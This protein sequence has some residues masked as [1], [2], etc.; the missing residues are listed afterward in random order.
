MKLLECRSLT[1]TRHYSFSSM[2]FAPVPVPD[3][4]IEIHRPLGL[5]DPFRAT[6]CIEPPKHLWS[7]KFR[8]SSRGFISQNEKSF[9]FTTLSTL[10]DLGIYGMNRV[11]RKVSRGAEVDDAIESV[12][13]SNGCGEFEIPHIQSVRLFPFDAVSK[14]T[15][16]EDPASNSEIELT[17]KE[18]SVII[19]RVYKLN[20]EFDDR[21]VCIASPDSRMTSVLEKLNNLK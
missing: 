1:S 16:H 5:F 10:M 3:E 18:S 15:C 7:S 12:I 8:G 2:R 6:A 17:W 4:I 9:A 20:F 14:V 11:I 13:Y 21:E 19:F